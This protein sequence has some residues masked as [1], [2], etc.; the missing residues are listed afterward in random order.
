MALPSAA[1]PP[2]QILLGANTA[3]PAVWT[4]T[5]PG[6]A[7][8]ESSPLVIDL[9]GDGV[10]DVVV[11]THGGRVIA[12]NGATGAIMWT[13]LASPGSRINSSAA[14]AD[15][16]GNGTLS[17]FI[18][19]GNHDPADRNAPPGAMLGFR[20]DGTVRPGFP[21]RLHDWA[22]PNR[23]PGVH[24][25]PAIGDIT[26]NGV[27][28]I[29]FGILGN[30]SIRSITPDGRA[31]W[32]FAHSVPSVF[33]NRDTIFSSPAL[34]D[35]TGDG[36][37]DFV[38][39][40]DQTPTRLPYPAGGPMP[41]G[42]HC[43]SV[44]FLSGTGQN[45]APVLS[46]HEIV[47]GSP[48]VGDIDGSGTPRIV[49]ASGNYHTNPYFRARNPATPHYCPNSA[50]H[51]RELLI[52]NLDGRVVHRID[53]GGTAMAE[54]ALADVTGN[55]VR[56]IVFGTSNQN[57]PAGGRVLAYDFVTRQMLW[58][59]PA[60]G[61]GGG[62]EDI[63]GAV[64]TADLTGDGRQDVLVPTG[65]GIYLLSGVDGSRIGAIN[66]GLISYQNTPVVT[67]VNGNG[68]LNI[69]TA[70]TTPAGAGVIQL[71]ELPNTTARL[72]E[73]GWHM[74]RGD[75]RRTGNVNPP[76]LTTQGLFADVRAGT[77][78]ANE[79]NWLA[80][81]RITTGYTR[82]DGA[83]V[84]RPG[85]PVHR[86]A[87]AAFMYRLAGQDVTGGFTTPTT[88]RFSDVPVGG[89]F[90]REIE[91]LASTGVTTGYGDGTFRPAGLIHRGAMAAFMY[92]LAGQDVTG[93][94]TTPTTA[95]F[96]DVPVGGPFFREIEWLASTGITTGYGDG[97]FRPRGAVHRGA[98]AAFLHRFANL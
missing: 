69:V 58:N 59:V 54:P 21:V 84:F 74:F 80:D 24:S 17:I 61:L 14:A 76:P 31:N 2:G 50:V 60:R 35:L 19:S 56:N 7:I 43:G 39:G 70:G 86:G 78:F 15:V 48:V 73:N 75:T 23:Y 53:T 98:M 55:G 87:M 44:R 96:N 81:Q 40:T 42:Q 92:R 47:R 72:G 27:P 83:R 41:E 46:R 52:L 9:N 29:T 91:W 38:I 82:A 90:F 20:A 65:S 68:R 63:I 51:S 33:F 79:I 67:D 1:N 25:T 66:E 8:W 11:G 37:T 12:V 85:N 13:G 62:T 95:R 6:E 94:F 64:S 26:S 30:N 89:P 77:P 5:L 28:D 4:V 16:D 88:A 36:H 71:F 57:N 18:G 32:T 3:N 22:T 93:G 10:K 97:T 49:V 34:V 45:V